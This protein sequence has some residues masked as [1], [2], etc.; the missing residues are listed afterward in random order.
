[1]LSEPSRYLGLPIPSTLPPPAASPESLEGTSSGSGLVGAPAWSGLDFSR[2]AQL[3]ERM[4]EPCSYEDLRVCL[5]DIAQ[6]NRL[7]FAHRPTLAWLDR[8]AAASAGRR[9]LRIVD[10]GCGNGDTLR[11]IEG[12]A[13]RRR[14]EVSLTGID[15]NPDAIRAAHE[16][17]G[18]SRSIHWR[19]G[20][21]L[22]GGMEG[23][24]DV[25]LCSLLTHHLD[26]RE[27]VQFLRR[28]EE[29]AER[30]WFINDL[31]RQPLPYHLFRLC[32]RFARWHRFVKHDGPI[33][34]R[35]SFVVE[36]WRALCAA[37]DLCGETVAI[38]ECRPARLCL[39][40]IKSH[41]PR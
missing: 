29:V 38:R 16:A 40:R 41:S 25:V 19:V 30:G 20:D 36:D 37:A 31:H 12:W 10:V 26:D 24:T 15:L 13:A 17:S 33:S 14:I 39:E 35:R 4:D 3:T 28:M 8:V 2:R 23:E 18:G 5:R 32:A 21:A 1:M 22:C 34:V 6:V 27:I 9:P 11:R 7:T